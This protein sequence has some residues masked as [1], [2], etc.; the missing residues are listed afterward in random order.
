M[1]IGM[2]MLMIVFALHAIFDCICTI[3]T[4]FAHTGRL[5]IPGAAWFADF[6]PK[7]FDE[8][9]VKDNHFIARLIIYYV[10]SASLTRL[11][12]VC[13]P[14]TG[15]YVCVTVLY[16]LQALSMEYEGFTGRSLPASNARLISCI[17]SCLAL[18]SSL[19]AFML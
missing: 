18:C 3:C 16:G 6:Y 19:M 8:E 13:I 15:T 12:M 17:C 10:A 11:V 7:L 1:H 14:C 2:L 5:P 9:F 4:L